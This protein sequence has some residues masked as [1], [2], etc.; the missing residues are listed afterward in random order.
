MT[1]PR[2]LVKVYREERLYEKADRLLRDLLK[3][4]PDDTNLAAALIEI[5]SVEAT[6]A[7]AKQLPD[8][9][10]ELSDQAASMIRQ[11]RTRFKGTVQ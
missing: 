1:S 8:R 11:Y 9:Q 3:T 4:S 7:G 10:R 2:E 5:I 6:E